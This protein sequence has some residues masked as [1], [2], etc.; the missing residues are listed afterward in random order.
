M[1]LAAF[2]GRCLLSEAAAAAAVAPGAV[3]IIDLTGLTFIRCGALEVLTKQFHWCRRRDIAMRLVTRQEVI[4]QVVSACMPSD[5]LPIFPSAAEALGRSE[6][7]AARSTGAA[8]G[9]GACG[10]RT[11]GGSGA[12]RAAAELTIATLAPSRPES[13]S[14]HFDPPSGSP[15]SPNCSKGDGTLRVTSGTEPVA[16]LIL[17]RRRECR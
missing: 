9:G 5:A 15:C 16:T 14:V 6:E 8:V 3:L 17:C 10:E 12:R 11:R 2:A 7:R 13:L 4:R 1:S